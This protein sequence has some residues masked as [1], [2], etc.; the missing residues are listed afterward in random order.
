MQL[1]PGGALPRASHE[2]PPAVGNK[3]RAEDAGVVRTSGGCKIA[4]VWDN[5]SETELDAEWVFD[6]VTNTPPAARYAA[7]LPHALYATALPCSGLL[8]LLGHRDRR[9]TARHSTSPERPEVPYSPGF[10]VEMGAS[11]MW[12]SELSNNIPS[13]DFKA[14]T[15]SVRDQ[16]RLCST[17]VHQ[18][19]L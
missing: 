1:R 10:E 17:L 14:V 3:L 19:A 6:K 16:L 7:P 12:G 18:G 5:G 9:A 2:R 13:F 4:V 15:T 11:L 8:Q